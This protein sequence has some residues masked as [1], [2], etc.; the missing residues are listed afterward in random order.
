M[1]ACWITCLSL[2]KDLTGL[3]NQ[4]VLR[5]NPES[6]QKKEN[7]VCKAG[8]KKSQ[9][10]DKVFALFPIQQ[11][12]LQAKCHGPYEVHSKAKDL[13][14]I[15]KKSGQEKIKATFSHQHVTAIS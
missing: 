7:F 8:A 5:E 9:E 15:V 4:L 14:Y 10:G 13:N 12:P 11:N 3:A 1:S 2:K 6:S